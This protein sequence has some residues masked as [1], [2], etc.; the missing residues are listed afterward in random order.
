MENKL[1]TH[2]N[3]LA[4]TESFRIRS[5]QT[6][7]IENDDNLSIL[8][9]NSNTR[10]QGN[11]G[12]DHNRHR[13]PI[14]FTNLESEIYVDQV[15]IE[16]KLPDWL[17]GTL[18]RNGPAKFHLSRQSF[19]HWFDGLAMLHRFS[20]KNGTMSYVNKFIKS[21]AF[22]ESNQKDKIAYREFAT[23]PCRS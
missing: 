13:N 3:G 11:N 20:F 4:D 10:I 19:N 1:N 2:H 14:G 9:I 22:K 16:G 23:D 18:I 7:N 15:I 5:N 21:N 8:A 17:S 6:P 12:K